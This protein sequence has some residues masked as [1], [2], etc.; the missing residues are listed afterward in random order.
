MVTPLGNILILSMPCVKFQYATR[1]YILCFCIGEN[2][3][4]ANA[5]NI[6][7]IKKYN[8]NIKNSKTYRDQASLYKMSFIMK[9]VLIIIFLFTS[10]YTYLQFKLVRVPHKTKVYNYG[11]VQ[12]LTDIPKK[13]KKSK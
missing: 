6:K 5:K 8:T 7:N 12:C 11:I 1:K 3:L 2:L 10:V 9:K 4:Q 13:T